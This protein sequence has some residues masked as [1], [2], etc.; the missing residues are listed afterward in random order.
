MSW[1]K[2]ICFPNGQG[3]EYSPAFLR[4][5]LPLET[6][7]TWSGK[8]TITGEAF[9]GAVDYQKKVDGA[10]T[11]TTPA[12]QFDTYKVSASGR[13]NGKLKAGGT[14]FSGSESYAGWW[15]SI[16]GKAVVVKAEYKNTFGETVTRELVSAELK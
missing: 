10:E 8:M 16:G 11:I 13:L 12:G 5:D 14:P 9:V 6:G 7:K 1:S 15:A 3:C 2:G 4:V